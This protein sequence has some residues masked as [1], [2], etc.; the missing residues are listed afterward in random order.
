[1]NPPTDYPSTLAH[2]NESILMIM[3]SNQGLEFISRRMKSMG[4]PRS[5]R[6]GVR[7]NYNDLLIEG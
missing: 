4:V 5:K 7:R 2:E 1:L 3:R 6:M